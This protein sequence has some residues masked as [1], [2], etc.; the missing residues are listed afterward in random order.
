MGRHLELGIA[1]IAH[2]RVDVG[3]QH[4]RQTL[5]LAMVDVT[6]KCRHGI[7]IRLKLPRPSG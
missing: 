6:C 5:E 7:L 2:S 3:E 1:A 4:A